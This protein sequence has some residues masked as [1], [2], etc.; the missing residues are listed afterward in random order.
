MGGWQKY[1]A[2][3]VRRYKGGQEEDKVKVRRKVY[4]KSRKKIGR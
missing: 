2:R 4:R 1:A 3:W